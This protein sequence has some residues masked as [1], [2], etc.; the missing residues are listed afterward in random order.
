MKNITINAAIVLAT[1]LIVSCAPNP[2]DEFD[3]SCAN[4]LECMGWYVTDYCDDGL[5]TTYVFYKEGAS[6]KSWGPFTTPALNKYTTGTL[7]CQADRRI[8]IGAQAGD[9]SWGV[10]LGGDRECKECCA[11]CNGMSYRFD[12][13]CQKTSGDR[14]AS[15]PGGFSA[16][17]EFSASQSLTPEK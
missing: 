4:D 3:S 2:R 7:K 13:H 1:V 16:R 17:E 10:G 11:L 6:V 12:L 8:C 14:P 9:V 15:L 5:D